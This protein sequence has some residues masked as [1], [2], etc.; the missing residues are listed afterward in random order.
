VPID[1]PFLLT[2]QA[3]WLWVLRLDAIVGRHALLQGMIH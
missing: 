1:P 2:E 3:L